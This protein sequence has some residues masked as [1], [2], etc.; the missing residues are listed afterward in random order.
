MPHG[1]VQFIDDFLEF[2]NKQDIQEKT[3]QNRR[4]VLNQLRIYLEENNENIYLH[5][6][7]KVK[8]KISNFFENN[9]S[10][11]RNPP[12]IHAITSFFEYLKEHRDFYEP[13]NVEQCKNSVLK[14]K[15]TYEESNAVQR[16]EKGKL[17]FEQREKLIRACR[18]SR[19]EPLKKEVMLKLILDAGLSR[20]ELLA[21]KPSD[22][23]QSNTIN[24]AEIKVERE[25]S[26]TQS[27]EIPKDDPRYVA[28]SLET[29]VRI[30]EL[31]DRK[32]REANEFLIWTNPSYRKPKRRLD[33]IFEEADLESLNLSIK[34]IQRN[35][36]LDLIEK[37][38]EQHR[39]QKY[40]GSKSSVTAD[41]VDKFS[42]ENPSH[43]P[44]SENKRI[45]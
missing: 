3:K 4:E 15:K 20:S 26:Q 27:Q 9:E 1:I 19:N 16:V 40:Y 24:P 28:I 31:I 39:I 25:W 13:S 43:Y 22:I 34:D 12:N 23:T 32:S 14:L 37:G 6:S 10:R 35:A 21:L 5:E 36:I 38:V 2:S 44:L 11:S 8:F 29:R 7:S 18:N 45:F 33:E 42:L 30:N 41:V 17:T